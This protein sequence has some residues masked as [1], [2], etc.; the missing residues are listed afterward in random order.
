LSRANTLKYFLLSQYLEPKT[1]DEPKKTNSKF[2]KSMDLEIANFDEKF[3]QILRAFDRSLLKNGVE[4]SI[5]GGIF[6]TDLLAL[7]ISKLANVK[8]EK[9]QI[10]DELR[11]E[12]TS[13]EKAFCYKLKLSGDLYFAKM[14]K[15]L[16]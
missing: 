3:M 15:V 13:F 4:I 5:Y 2:K 10:L 11:S 9:E 14:S 16:L 12:Q 8:F 6:E 7:A 1:L